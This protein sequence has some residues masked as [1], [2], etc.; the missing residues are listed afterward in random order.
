MLLKWKK[1]EWIHRLLLVLLPMSIIVFI[2]YNFGIYGSNIDWVSQHVTFPDYFRKIFLET[3]QLFPDFSMNL[4]AG[5]NFAQFTYYGV[6]RP[7]VLLSYLFPNIS[8]E[9]CIISFSILYV[10]LSVQIFYSWMK[11]K[12]SSSWILL[13]TSCLFV[14]STPIIFHSHRHIMFMCYFPGLLIGLIGVDSYFEKRK[15]GL[16]VFGIFLM[17]L[18]SYF[19]SVSG[20]GVIC[21]Y[22]IYVWMKNYPNKAWKEFLIDYSKFLGWILLGIGLSGF[23]LLPTA[24]AMI[25]QTRPSL[26]H[27]SLID[28]FIPK[29]GFS[30]ILYSS[31]TLGF[32][33]IGLLGILQGILKK[34]KAHRLLGCFLLIILCIPLFQY[35][36]NGFQYVRAKSL[37]P[38]I[39]LVCLMIGDMV[40]EWKKEQIHLS[41]W[42]VAL[43]LVQ[44]FFFNR[45]LYQVGFLIDL[46]LLLF[47][48]FFLRKKSW[49][50]LLC[51]YLFIPFVLNI[52]ANLQ[53]EYSDK[54]LLSSIH[55][56]DKSKL[57]QDTLDNNHGFYRFDDA[58]TLYCVNQIDDIRQWKTTQYSS[59]SNLDYRYFYYDVMKQPMKSGNHVTIPSVSNPYFNSFMGI[60][61]L[62]NS[63]KNKKIEYGYKKIATKE[64]GFIEENKDVLPIAYVSYD[65]LSKKQFE[66]LTY[67]YTMEALYQNTII[68]E[69]IPYKKLSPSVKKIKPQFEVIDKTEGL[70]IRQT[71]NEIRINSNKDAKIKLKLKKPLGKNQFLILRFDVDN[72]VKEDKR[73]TVISVNGIS[74]RLNSKSYVY[75]SGKS[76]FEYVLSSNKGIQNMNVS[77]SKG[78]YS[79]KNI[80]YYI[81]DANVLKKRKEQITAL[82]DVTW[83]QGILSGYVQAKKDGYFVTSIPFQKGLEIYIDDQK[84]QE[85]KVNTAFLGAKIPKGQHKVEIKY[86]LPGKM[87]GIVLSGGSIIILFGMWIFTK[88]KARRKKL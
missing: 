71:N 26:Q 7:D 48:L 17:I 25:L 19:Y 65:M 31:Y 35:I 62:Y 52:N 11:P 45:K 69:S 70:Q 85:E 8:M 87:E 77:F 37:I 14:L 82:Q 3:G 67:P 76:D 72:I 15:I 10:L 56:K 86:H 50:P 55:N 24:Y 60:R 4:G 63:G 81:A 74:N 41:F 47:L 49:K 88:E 68:E 20:L 2:I 30:S 64:D 39:P 33:C 66:T 79:L 9:V 12:I 5:Q 29:E 16:L 75:R 23:F 38:F 57:I 78:S 54:E 18:C 73:N 51:V 40:E 84:V 59:I 46:F 21:V 43:C 28:L 34:E 83:Q 61:F 53:E 42:S 36:L 58:S 1:I 32:T 44:V 22:G 80:E 27:P 13:F 6:M